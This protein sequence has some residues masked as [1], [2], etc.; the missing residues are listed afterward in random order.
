MDELYYGAIYFVSIVL[1][2]FFG[3]IVGRSQVEKGLDF[4]GRKKKEVS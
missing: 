1:F 3:M 4:F 2:Y